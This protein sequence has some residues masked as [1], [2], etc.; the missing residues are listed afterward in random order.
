MESEV[1]VNGELQVGNRSKGGKNKKGG[2][3]SKK[4]HSNENYCAD[5]CG[6]VRLLWATRQTED[7]DKVKNPDKYVKITLRELFIYLGFLIVRCLRKLSSRR[8]YSG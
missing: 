2:K 4:K 1:Y 7:I 5:M 6:F 8:F 3:N